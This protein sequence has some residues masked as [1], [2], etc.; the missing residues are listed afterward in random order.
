MKDWKIYIGNTY[1]DNILILDEF[2]R[3]SGK[4]NIQM[5]KCKC[6]RCGNEFEATSHDVLR[7][8]SR[9]VKSC[10]CLLKELTSELGKRTG[11]TN[12]RK[13]DH[14]RPRKW[15]TSCYK[16]G[17]SLPIYTN[18]RSMI[19]RCYYPKDVCYKSYGERGITVCEEWKDFDNYREWAY[20]NGYVDN[21]RAHRLDNNV[22]YTPENVMFLSEENHNI[23]TQYMRKQNITSMTRE[24][25]VGVINQLG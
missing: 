8:D 14:T 2:K 6:L 21:Y 19:S 15:K 13:I 5:F 18:Y 3:H 20:N 12:I 23:I 22:G 11:S 16:N 17:K 24:E 25:V 10:G 9:A 1:N 7:K 4:R